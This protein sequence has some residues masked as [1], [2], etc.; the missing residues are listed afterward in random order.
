MLSVS[1]YIAHHVFRQL[2][3]KIKFIAKT[4]CAFIVFLF[5]SNMQNIFLNLFNKISALALTYSKIFAQFPRNIF[6]KKIPL[7]NQ[8]SV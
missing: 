2:N 8:K 6:V 4:W 3:G 5:T 7:Y 1:C